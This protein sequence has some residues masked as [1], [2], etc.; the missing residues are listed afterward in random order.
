MSSPHVLLLCGVLGVGKTTVIREVATRLNCDRLAGFYTEDTREGG[1]R[2]GIL[3]KT[4]DGLE[5]AIAHVNFPK[6]N[7]VGKYGVD[8]AAID[9]VA[10]A[11]PAVTPTASVYLV[12]EIGK[13][14]CLSQHFVAALR[15]L[16]AS[17]KT[18]VAT[19][20][21]RGTGPSAEVK[22]REDTLL[23]EMSRAN[24]DA[25]LE[26]I[27]EWLNSQARSPYL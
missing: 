26:R 23:W 12:D 20:A 25:M 16:L 5:R 19:I 6:R 4:F 22:Q 24:R 14:E 1:Q 18:V 21:L 17:K 10:A 13:M 9:G 15:T 8:F 3:L 11:A 7:R 27:L 2:R